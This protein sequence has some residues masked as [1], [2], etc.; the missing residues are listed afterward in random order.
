M[1]ESPKKRPDQVG[2]KAFQEEP[3]QEIESP[4]RIKKRQLGSLSLNP[5]AT[6]MPDEDVKD[7][8]K[9]EAIFKNVMSNFEAK[10]KEF[11]DLKK[12]SK[13]QLIQYNREVKIS[14]LSRDWRKSL[15][16]NVPDC[17]DEKHDH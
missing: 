17:S 2:I 1:S 10:Q 11:E 12:M 4:M 8:K 3:Q 14:N 5:S 16:M 6:E 13:E 7:F 15:E 9:F